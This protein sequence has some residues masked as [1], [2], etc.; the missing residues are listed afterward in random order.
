MLQHFTAWLHVRETI[1]IVSLGTHTWPR[2]MLLG[3]AVRDLDWSISKGLEHRLGVGGRPWLVALL[4]LR[5]FT[6]V[7]DLRK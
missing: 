6:T 3:V 7:V 4:L 2:G 5:V 1:W